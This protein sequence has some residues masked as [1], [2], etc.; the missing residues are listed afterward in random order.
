MGKSSLKI[1]PFYIDELKKNWSSPTP[2]I[3]TLKNK[4]IYF[5]W[6]WSVEDRELWVP[7]AAWSN[8]WSKE[9]NK[10]KRCQQQL[11]TRV[12]LGARWQPLPFPHQPIRIIV[13]LV[14]NQLMSNF[15]QIFS[16]SNEYKTQSVPKIRI[17]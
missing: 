12:Q 9:E 4:N 17:V 10:I 6:S 16:K 14:K 13:K 2:K 5:E 11:Q 7:P 1:S 8:S 3:K 15:E